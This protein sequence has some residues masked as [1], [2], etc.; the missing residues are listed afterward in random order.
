LVQHKAK[1][2]LLGSRAEALAQ[3]ELL[4]N[5]SH[6]LRNPL[7]A[8]IGFNELILGTGLTGQQRKYAEL[9]QASSKSLLSLIENI[10]DGKAESGAREKHAA[11]NAVT[12]D[13]SAPAAKP[14]PA[15]GAYNILIA[16]DHPLIR[17]LVS[18][19]LKDAGCEPE[20][21]ENGQKALS[22]LDKADFDLII[23]DNHMPVMTGIEAIKII[24]GRVDGKRFIPI[25]SLTADATDGSRESCA[26]AG[27][28]VYMAKPFKVDR[29]LAA[30]TTLARYGRDMRLYRSYAFR[31]EHSSGAAR[32]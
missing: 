7:Q 15:A 11:E 18:T 2:E 1:G 26:S 29:F 21:A 16:E 23:M 24:R 20:L 22:K 8:I 3:R 28:N 9:I 31:N 32:A 12:K 6:E 27:A 30:V 19:I 5:V 14:H 25:L 17:A 4:L 13:G 10:L